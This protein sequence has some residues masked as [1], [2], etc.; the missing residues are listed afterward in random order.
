MMDNYRYRETTLAKGDASAATAFCADLEL[1][2]GSGTCS[3]AGTALLV[4]LEID[5][6][7]ATGYC[8]AERHLERDLNIL[9]ALRLPGTG[10]AGS[11]EHRAEEVAQSTQPS[12][13]DLL[14]A[15]AAGARRKAGASQHERIVHLDLLG[16]GVEQLQ[17]LWCAR[18]AA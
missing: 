11:A 13:V 15:E 5:R 12:E 3:T 18:F 9:P 14:E 10:S 2:A 17:E 16:R 7:L 4:D 8:G 6:D 1:G